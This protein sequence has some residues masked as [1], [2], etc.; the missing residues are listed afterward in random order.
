MEKEDTKDE[1]G[2]WIGYLQIAVIVGIIAIA[3]YFARA[4]EQVAIDENGTLGEKLSPIV[5]IMKPES[6]SYNFRLETTGSITLKERVTIA[7]E[8]K[9]RVVWVS[10]KFEPSGTIEANE[11]FIK[12]DPRVYELEV[13][14]AAYELAVH[15]IELE[16]Q[17][18]LG[19][20]VDRFEALR[21][22]AST[23]LDLAR[24]QLSK[25]ELSLPYSFRVISSSVEVGE[26]AGTAE[27]TGTA[28]ILG[29]A[30]RPDSIRV[31]V[32]IEM[33][34]IQ[35]L[36]PIIGRSVKVM[37]ASDELSGVVTG[38]SSIL[39]PKSRLATAYIKFDSEL[40]PSE[41]PLPNS[42][43]E[44]EISGPTEQNVFLLPEISE[45]SLG[46]IWL[47]R[48]GQ[49]ESFE[50][51]ILA[52]NNGMLVVKVFDVGDGIAIDIPANVHDGMTVT[53]VPIGN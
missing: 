13:E 11:V 30:Y 50:P 14:E 32:P 6:Q 18:S 5:T 10:S 46:Q 20:D 2:N 1:R 25:T 3:I 47:V 39:A 44:I 43:V 29:L 48:N 31:D 17:K 40:N 26:L 45:K 12:I 4:P 7:S 15:E 16:K 33:Q 52:R 37:T 8:V 23:R 22:Q 42:F 35:T 21:N 27:T 38:I 28:S 41:F 9:G 24:L 53:A 49:L 36:D 19:A 34:D 51:Q